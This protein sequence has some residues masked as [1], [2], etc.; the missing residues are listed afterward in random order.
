METLCVRVWSVVHKSDDFHIFSVEPIGPDKYKY[1]LKITCKGHLFGINGVIAGVQLQLFG[2]W[3]MHAKFGRQF[4]LHG[5]APWVDSYL[6]ISYFLRHCL[7]FVSEE[8]VDLIVDTFGMDTFEVLSNNPEKVV[9]LLGAEEAEVLLGAW[10]LAR[11][12]SELTTLFAGHDVTS[13]QMKSLFNAF[14]GTVR[15]VIEGNPY[16]LLEVQGFNLLTADAVA[17]TM[18]IP[19]SDPR[20]FEGAVLWVLQESTQSGHLFVQG[21]ELVPTLKK[22]VS[23]VPGLDTFNEVGLI[24]GMSKAVRDLADRKSVYLNKSAVYLPKFYHFE[25]DAANQLSKF[26]TPLNLSID[27]QSFLK[28]YSDLNAITLSEAQKEAV[29]N[30]VGSRVLVLTGLPGTGKTT[31]LRT[32]VS[33]FQRTGVSFALMAP[34]GIAAK[35]LSAVTG[36]P[37]ATIHRTFRFNG[38]AWEFNGDNKFSIGAVVLDESSMIDQELFFRVLDAL[39]EGTILVLVGDDAQL[40]SVGPGNVLRELIKCPVIPTVRLTQIFRQAQGSEIVLNSHRINKGEPISAGSL[41]SDFSFI[42][43]TDE[44]KIADLVVRMATKLKSRDAN[45]QVLS[46]KYDGTVGVNNLNNLLREALNP[47]SSEK[48]EHSVGTLKFREG[49]RLMVIRNDYELGVYNGDMGKLIEVRR[50]VLWVRIHG[51]GESGLDVMVEIP[52]KDVMTKLR[53]A[54][55]ISAH[56]SQ[57][58]E[59]DVVILPMVKDYGRM[60][61]RKVFYTALTRAKKKA[62]VIGDSYAI[63]KAIGNDQV[64]LRNTGLS[65][66]ILE[67]VKSSEV[68]KG[69]DNES[70]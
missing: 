65:D 16:R 67:S 7:G 19:L 50:E 9:T 31:V 12:S 23:N 59:F 69:L 18:G 51:V 32:I 34:T 42:S 43:M 38:E 39:V 63:Q 10:V 57:G 37:A 70:S 6:G 21:I 55:A 49:D 3:V 5:W 44:D 29:I 33:L 15:S 41:D 26:L 62:W 58:S 14:G 35:R 56:K 28:E 68:E 60:L 2:H 47:A 22:L 17:Q 54:Y 13:E 4:N 45:F 24:E 20:R 61:Q 27:P 64:T 48:K 46:P 52:K 36:H 66:A 1:D 11:T 53:L 8:R 30:L 40:P 25:K